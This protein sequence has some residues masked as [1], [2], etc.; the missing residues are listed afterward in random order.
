M[1]NEAQKI[2]EKLDSIS[3]DL[4]FIKK[5]VVDVDLVLTEEDMDSLDQSEIDFKEGKTKRL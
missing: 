1:I 2:I 5:H 3:S 4:N